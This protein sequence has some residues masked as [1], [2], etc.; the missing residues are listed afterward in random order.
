MLAR[1]AVHHTSSPKRRRLLQSGQLVSLG[2]KKSACGS[3]DPTALSK[4][5]SE[6][7]SGLGYRLAAL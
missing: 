4:I 7:R 5:H 2:K 3:L 6:R 1:L